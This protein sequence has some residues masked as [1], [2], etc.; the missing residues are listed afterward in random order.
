MKGDWVLLKDQAM[1]YTHVRG[2]SYAR[3]ATIV[4]IKPRRMPKEKTPPP[5]KPEPEP[6]RAAY[7]PDPPKFEPPQVQQVAH[8]KAEDFVYQSTTRP[9]YNSNTQFN[10]PAESMQNQ[11]P[12]NNLG[13]KTASEFF[14]TRPVDAD[15]KNPN[16]EWELQ[17]DGKTWRPNTKKRETA[18]TFPVSSGHE[19]MQHMLKIERRKDYKEFLVSTIQHFAYTCSS[20]FTLNIS[21]VFY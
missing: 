13:F 21:L 4:P 16:T 17:P 10:P 3:Q 9:A 7:Y 5:P 19:R 15:P 11:E 6:P 12:S 14:G 18:M 20:S 1:T 8:P 2:T